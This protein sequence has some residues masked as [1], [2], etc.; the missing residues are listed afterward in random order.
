MVETEKLREYAFEIIG[1]RFNSQ[2]DDTMVELISG[3][4]NFDS[5]KIINLIFT[6]SNF[7]KDT[8]IECL[9]NKCLVMDRKFV[10]AVLFLLKTKDVDFCRFYSY[11]MLINYYDLVA[12]FVIS[13]LKSVDLFDPF[14]SEEFGKF[15]QIVLA[16]CDQSVE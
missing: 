7:K 5:L 1:K 6:F 9:L 16:N 13:N 4:C 2:F 10:I 11:G 15:E 12:K 14:N 8:I 3:F